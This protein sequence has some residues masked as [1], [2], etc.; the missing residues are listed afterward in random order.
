[1]L[2][3]SSHLNLVFSFV[4]R[5]RTR[6]GGFWYTRLGICQASLPPRLSDE[7]LED[8]VRRE[9]YLP[10]SRCNCE[11]VLVSLC[12]RYRS[13]LERNP[14]GRCVDESLKI[15]G[16]LTVLYTSVSYELEYL[17]DE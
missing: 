15:G 12:D 10:K 13:K 3:Q 14:G 8:Y 17:L 5:A 4:P 2:L 1:M 16:A 11:A 9:A 6:S 7:M